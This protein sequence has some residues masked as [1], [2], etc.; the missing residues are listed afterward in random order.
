M[1]KNFVASMPKLGFGLMRLPKIDGQIDI[2]HTCSAS[3]RR[4]RERRHR[5]NQWVHCVIN[6]LYAHSSSE[7]KSCERN[8]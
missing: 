6:S 8:K 7:E 4:D 1:D 5:G 2:A 3:V